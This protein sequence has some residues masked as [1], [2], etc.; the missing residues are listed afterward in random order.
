M[1]DTD[2]TNVCKDHLEIHQTILEV[3]KKHS[4][5]SIQ[6]DSPAYVASCY[7]SNMGKLLMVDQADY[8]TQ[9][10]FFDANAGSEQCCV[11]VRDIATGE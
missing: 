4:A 9:H 3:L 11:D 2:D 1:I 10:I 6:D 5:M 7:E 8:N